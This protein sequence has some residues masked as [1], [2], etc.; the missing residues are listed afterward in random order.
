MCGLGWKLDH[1]FSGILSHRFSSTG[2]GNAL[3]AF[4]ALFARAGRLAVDNRRAR[5]PTRELLVYPILFT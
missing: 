5:P 2:G 1:V 4:I 3:T